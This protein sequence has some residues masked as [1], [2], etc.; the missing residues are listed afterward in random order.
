MRGTTQ[1][2]GIMKRCFINHSLAAS[3]Y[4]R[5]ALT[6]SDVQYRYGWLGTAGR[7]ENY[8]YASSEAAEKEAAWRIRNIISWGVV[9]VPDWGPEPPPDERPAQL[10][11]QGLEHYLQLGLQTPADVLDTVLELIWNGS[12]DCGDLE[13]GEYIEEEFADDGALF[14]AWLRQQL[15]PLLAQQQAR[16]AAFP[17]HTDCDRLADAFDYLNQH[18]IVAIHFLADVQYCPGPYAAAAQHELAE[19]AALIAEAQQDDS[20]GHC[21]YNA[22]LLQALD[23]PQV[24]RLHF[25]AYHTRDA[26][27]TVAI[28]QRVA[29]ALQAQG[30][31]VAWEGPATLSLSGLCWQKRFDGLDWPRHHLRGLPPRPTMRLLPE[32]VAGKAIAL[33]AGWQQFGLGRRWQVRQQLAAHGATALEATQ[34][35]ARR[36]FNL[37][38]YAGNFYDELP[39]VFEDE[40]CAPLAPATGPFGNLRLRL[41]D[42]LRE[43]LS[44]PAIRV[45]DFSVGKP[46]TEAE[47]G[48]CERRL[49]RL[50][51]AYL[52][53]LYQQVGE[54][55]LRWWQQTSA[56]ESAGEAIQIPPLA[57]LLF[58]DSADGQVPPLPAGMYLFDQNCDDSQMALALGE[59]ADPRLYRVT[60]STVDFDEGNP[61]HLSSYM[62]LLLHRCGTSNR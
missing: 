12:L 61:V 57:Q 46:L 18:G 8:K 54:V 45:T 27:A 60:K 43:L 35:H 50:L 59:E 22:R 1:K 20:I 51:P 25:G 15:P 23:Q 40:L 16:E 26:A 10:Y 17:A 56:S 28:G 6:G 7:L 49:G 42:M 41:L 48:R 19:V 47:L 29:A 34:P 13:I 52:R 3:W 31:C 11:L 39:L 24:L 9:E 4:W 58:A 62:D 5:V 21:Y 38:G 30:L 2:T 32:K 37:A 44:Q 36:D 55:R 53:A 14:A 33:A